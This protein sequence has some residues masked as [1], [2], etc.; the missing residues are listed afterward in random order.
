MKHIGQI[1][2]EHIESHKLVKKKIAAQVGITYNYLSTIFTKE[3]IDLSL[4]EKLCVAIGLNPH[5]VFDYPEM[6]NK[7]Y[8]DIYAHT[9]IGDASVQIGQQASVMQQLLDEKD[10]IIE[11][12]D[13]LLAEK[14]KLIEEK[15]RM[16]K[17]LT[18]SRK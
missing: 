1:L 11:G 18:E 4:F 16:I 8:S 9:N 10:R 3:T 12:K 15:E 14:D 13:K 6:P 5:I 7:S 17:F 2:K